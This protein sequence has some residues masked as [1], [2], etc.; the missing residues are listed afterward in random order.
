[1]ESEPCP[2]HSGGVFALPP[3]MEWFYRQY[4]PEYTV[5]AASRELME[6]IYPES[7]SILTIPRQ[8]DGSLGGVVFQ[9]AHRDA[10]ETVSPRKKGRKK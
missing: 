4:H 9:L 2:Y 7:G 1:M 10:S 3:A 8:L 6:F 5:P